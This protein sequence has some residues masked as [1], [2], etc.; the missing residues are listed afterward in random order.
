MGNI[1]IN[2]Q[3][4]FAAADDLVE[5]EITPTIQAL[6]EKL[7]TGSYATISKYLAQWRVARAPKQEIPDVPSEFNSYI[8]KF[9]TICYKEASAKLETEKEAFRLE[10]IKLSEDRLELHKII[11]KL[12]EE[13]GLTITDKI[14]L[15]KKLETANQQINQLNEELIKTQTRLEASEQ[16]RKESADRSDRLEQQLASLIKDQLVTA[17][18]LVATKEISDVQ[19][20]KS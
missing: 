4:V 11:Q 2:E 19:N 12:E 16:R 15:E 6:R 7:G 13:C 18:K 8:K 9:W 10:R 17:N 5:K 1:G 14:R 20:H 3:Q